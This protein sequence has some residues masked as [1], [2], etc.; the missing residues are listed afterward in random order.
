MSVIFAIQSYTVFIQSGPVDL[1]VS[2]YHEDK[3]RLTHQEIVDEALS[4]CE[5][6]GMTFT[7]ND[8]DEVETLEMV[9]HESEGEKFFEL[10]EQMMKNDVHLAEDR[11]KEFIKMYETSNYAG[12]QVIDNVLMTICGMTY[13]ALFDYRDILIENQKEAD[14]VQ[15]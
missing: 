14:K 4:Y 13:K 5:D 10:L 15:S 6:E 11:G 7:Q 2:I 9:V 8:I 1:N 3:T 12:K